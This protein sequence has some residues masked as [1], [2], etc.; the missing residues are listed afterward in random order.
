MLNHNWLSEKARYKPEN[1][2]NEKE[3]ITMENNNNLVEKQNDFAVELDTV[4][5]G[6]ES[7]VI[8]DCPWTC[9]WTCSW[10]GFEQ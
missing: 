9:S 1:F 3:E 6:G 5:G 10:T 4:F 7:E 8:G 2:Y